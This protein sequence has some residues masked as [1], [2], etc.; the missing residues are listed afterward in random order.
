MS[1]LFVNIMT[2]IVTYC[3][4]VVQQAMFASCTIVNA[5]VSFY[6]TGRHCND[7]T[8]SC[9]DSYYSS[10][11]HL[12]RLLHKNNNSANFLSGLYFAIYG[13]IIIAKQRLLYV[14]VY[15]Y[16]I[17][18]YIFRYRYMVVLVL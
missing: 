11:C 3:T 14:S 1:C 13:V 4:V 2:T 12:S 15:F 7:K 16:R 5:S 9:V 18:T 17:I 8:R 6:G 10:S